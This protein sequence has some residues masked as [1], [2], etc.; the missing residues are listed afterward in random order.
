MEGEGQVFPHSLGTLEF[1]CCENGESISQTGD[2]KSNGSLRAPDSKGYSHEEVMWL[3]EQLRKASLRRL[4][5]V[6]KQGK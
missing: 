3:K 5:L 2:A 6:I 4:Q 1:P